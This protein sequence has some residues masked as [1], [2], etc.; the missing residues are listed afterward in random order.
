MKPGS[1]LLTVTLACATDRSTPARK[2]VSPARAPEERSRPGIGIFTETEVMLTM[3]PKRRAAMPSTARWISSI[4]VAMLAT[5]PARMAARSSSRK[6][7]KGGP[8]AGRGGD[9]LGGARRA[10]GV[11]AV[12]DHGR[13]GPGERLGAGAP[14]AAAGAA[15]DGPAALDPEVEHGGPPRPAAGG[16][17]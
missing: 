7:R 17:D 1:R 10:V 16:G 14:Q 3:R 8:P 11:D 6:S 9:L 13:A 4:G 15:D 5:T 12:D 2:A